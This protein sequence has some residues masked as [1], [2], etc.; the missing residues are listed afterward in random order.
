VELAGEAGAEQRF[1]RAENYSADSAPTQHPFAL[2]FVFR[3]K[4]N[5]I[6]HFSA[7]LKTIPRRGCVVRVF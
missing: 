2:K 7:A 6:F 3:D 5:A 1:A 4:I